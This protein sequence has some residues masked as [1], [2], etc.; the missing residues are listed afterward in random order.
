MQ[1]LAETGLIGFLFLLIAIFYI[2]SIFIIQLLKIYKLNKNFKNRIYFYGP[3]VVYLFPFMPTG[4]FFNSWVN[5][6]VYLPMGFLLY[7]VY[8][9]HD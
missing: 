8:S 3:S 2:Y 9:K 6:M 5:I 1:L 4:N 7:E